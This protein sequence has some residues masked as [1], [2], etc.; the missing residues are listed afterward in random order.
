MLHYKTGA[1]SFGIRPQNQV[2]ITVKEHVGKLHNISFP[3][4]YKEKVRVYFAIAPRKHY[5]S[6]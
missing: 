6:E 5:F 2:S 3:R 4:K 1:V